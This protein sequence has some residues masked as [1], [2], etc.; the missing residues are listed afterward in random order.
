MKII[1]KGFIRKTKPGADDKEKELIA[2]IILKHDD[3]LEALYR[4]YFDRL[5][6]FALRITGRMD[7]IEEVIN[8]VMLVV[9]NK[10]D[11]YNQTCRPSTWIFGIAYNKARKYR[12]GPNNGVEEVE[13]DDQGN[14]EHS[15][16]NPNWVEQVEM[17]DQ[18]TKAL[19]ILSPEHRLV[20]ELT[21]YHGMHYSEIAQIAECP[22]NTV[23]TRMFHARK[24]LA[25]VLRN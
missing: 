6:R 20:I 24:K 8:D 19:E 11:S 12:T 14:E 7:C 13:F 21:Y 16:C 2:R 23:K 1:A 25:Q 4:L 5:F 17:Q 9:W 18:M 15:R 10:A 3:A 22:E